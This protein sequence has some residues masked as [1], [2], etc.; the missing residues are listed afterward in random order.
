MSRASSGILHSRTAPNQEFPVPL[1]PL[2]GWHCDT[3]KDPH[4]DISRRNAD[5][6]TRLGGGR[7]LRL[8]S[9]A[10]Q[11]LLLKEPSPTREDTEALLKADTH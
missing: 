1:I 8:K 10:F 3:S 2:I 5:L 4:V 11:V 6:Q 9:A 7:I